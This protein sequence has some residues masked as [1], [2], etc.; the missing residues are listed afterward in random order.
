MKNPVLKCICAMLLAAA[1]LTAGCKREAASKL[2]P[3]KLQTDWYPQPEHGGFYEAQLKGYY[4]DEGLD[5]TIL[6]GGPFNNSEQQVAM[7]TID[8]GMNSSDHVLESVSRGEPLVAIAATMQNDPQGIMVHENSPVK[9]FADVEG[10]TVAV[11]PGST[12]FMYL[13]KKYQWKNVREIP[14]NFSVA[15][16]VSDPN[17][18]QQAFITSE[19][20]FAKK[21]GAEPRFLLVSD[22]GYAPYRVT[23]TTRNMIAQHPD[24][25]AKFVRAS[26]KGWRDYMQ[27]PTAVNAVIMKLNPAMNQEWMQFSW[28]QLKDHNFVMG[29]APDGSQ[30]GQF[31][32]ERWQR[33]YDQLVSLKVITQPF[34]P[35][36]AYTTQFLPKK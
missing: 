26:L 17:Y 9:T 28:Q 33:M 2:Y 11:K 4:R 25:V 32:A 19:P 36:V 18:I 7:G 10:H 5:V 1:A 24:I 31:D 3:V 21:A 20:F 12:W 6:P 15:T 29:D 16:F 27:D 35:K 23:Y 8:F 34:D 30:Q 14:T 22:T 13:E